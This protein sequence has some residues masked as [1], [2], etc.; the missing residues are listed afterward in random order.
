[1]QVF[2]DLYSIGIRCDALWETKPARKLNKTVDQYERPIR[3][4]NH[5]IAQAEKDT[6]RDFF[7]GLSKD[8]R[9]HLQLLSE[10]RADAI[11]RSS[12][13]RRVLETLFSDQLNLMCSFNIV[14]KLRRHD[15]E[16]LIKQKHCQ[17]TDFVKI[18][19]HHYRIHDE[20]L[21]VLKEFLKVKDAI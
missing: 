10:H 13:N 9:A 18:G 21:R 14:E 2:W 16:A 11:S 15:V 1:M 8:L 4:V 7:R 6:F 19:E 5:E 17:L 20:G 12:M 3:K